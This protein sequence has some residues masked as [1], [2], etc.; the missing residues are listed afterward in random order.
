MDSKLADLE[1]YFCDIVLTTASRLQSA[2]GDP[3]E[4]STSTSLSLTFS[5]EKFEE[6]LLKCIERRA[7]YFR[8]YKILRIVEN[9]LQRGHFHGKIFENES[10]RQL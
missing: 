7:T 1:D 3:I 5:C 10:D 2:N 4:K 8:G 9:L 6:E